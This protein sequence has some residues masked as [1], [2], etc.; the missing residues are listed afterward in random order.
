MHHYIL[1]ISSHLWSLSRKT[2][3]YYH[4]HQFCVVYTE[5]WEQFLGL[6]HDLGH[7]VILQKYI[8]NQVHKLLVTVVWEYNF[9]LNRHEPSHETRTITFVC[10]CDGSSQGLR[11][12]KNFISSRVDDPQNRGVEVD[13]HNRWVEAH[14]VHRQTYLM[15]YHTPLFIWLNFQYIL[16][17]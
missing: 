16:T 1:H 15:S 10:S 2:Y 8:I 7:L 12:S 11:S 6:V 3:N 4:K 14:D 17:R 9:G 5:T 13:S